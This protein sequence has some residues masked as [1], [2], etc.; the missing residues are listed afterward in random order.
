M[1]K[2]GNR[3]LIIGGGN[4]GQFSVVLTVGEDEQFFTLTDSTISS[5]DET[6]IVTGGQAG[7]FPRNQA[8]KLAAAITAVKSFFE[9]G[10]PAASLTWQRD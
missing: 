7:R 5:N 2:I 9:S 3:S 4:E 8:I 6:T 1:L 10:Q